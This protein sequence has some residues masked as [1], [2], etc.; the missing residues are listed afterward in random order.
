MKS[1][2]LSR[3]GTSTP[4]S[5]FSNAASRVSAIADEIGDEIGGSFSTP[6]R[7]PGTSSTWGTRGG[8]SGCGTSS[9]TTRPVARRAHRA[10]RLP[11]QRFPESRPFR[12]SAKI[13]ARIPLH[14]LRHQQP[15]G[16]PGGRFQ[17]ARSREGP[18][19]VS[20]N[21]VCPEPRP[22]VHGDRDDLDEIYER[23]RS[24]L[25]WVVPDPRLFAFSALYRLFQQLGERSS[26]PDRRHLKL[27]KESKAISKATESG[28]ASF[29]NELEERI[30]ARNSQVLLGFGLS[31]LEMVA[32]NVL[33]SA[34]IG[35]AVLEKSADGI[36]E[37]AEQFRTRHI[38]L[39]S[40]LEN[41]A[42]TVSGLNQSLKR[43]AGA[44]IDGCFDSAKG[45]IVRESLDMVE[46]YPADVACGRE[47]ADYAGLIREYYGFYLEFRRDLIAA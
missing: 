36:R 8:R 45:R 25:A 46:H 4:I 22:D 41:L 5:C 3:G 2:W 11:G 35:Q 33:D 43:E 40:T 19:G 38:A 15:N 7:S 23:V 13:P 24:E 37:A 1:E 27:W 16:T 42:D 29:K 20:A 17:T 31:R 39:Q 6:A 32:A 9:F 14:Y 10:C 12:A 44:R 30:L 21:P 26:K 34:R 28:F 47:T 18:E